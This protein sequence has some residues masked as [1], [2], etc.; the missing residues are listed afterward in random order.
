[1]CE[2]PVSKNAPIEEGF[3]WYRSVVEQTRWVVMEVWREEDTNYW[4]CGE[5]SSEETHIFMDQWHRNGSEWAGPLLEPAC[6]GCGRHDP[7]CDCDL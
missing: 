4:L 5:R 7:Y 6:Q 3:Y 2:L 1:M